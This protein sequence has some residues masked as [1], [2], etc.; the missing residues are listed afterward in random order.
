MTIK[1]PFLRKLTAIALML[2]GLSVSAQDSEITES[3]YLKADSALWNSLEAKSAVCFERMEREPEKA[4]SLRAVYKK[5][6]DEALRQ[7]IE[8]AMKYS[9][10]PSGLHRIYMLRNIIEKDTLRVLLDA[11]SPEIKGSC[12]G[13][14]IDRW[15]NTQQLTIGDTVRRFPAVTPDNMAYN[16]D[17]T[18][19]KHLLLIY[20]GLS[21][22]GKSGRDNLAQ[23]RKD[24]SP[25]KL[26]IL[27]YLNSSDAKDLAKKSGQDDLPILTISDFLSEASPIRID[28]ASQASPTCFLFDREGKLVKTLT[29]FSYDEFA[30]LIN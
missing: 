19:G 20:E 30:P 26:E 29:G 25:E 3:N 12:H 5:L 8:L 24:F 23:L 21:C 7:N 28:Y 17:K 13:L 16:W 2:S 4:D 22:M 6:Y 14:L 15:I 27:V 1:N 9:S 18:S 11:L 10:T